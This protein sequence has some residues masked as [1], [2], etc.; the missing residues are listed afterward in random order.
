V[1]SIVSRTRSFVGRSIPLLAGAWICST[2]AFAG[3]WTALTHQAPGGVN[4]MLLLPD[5]TV[6]CANNDGNNIGNAWYRL[7]PDVH[8]SY[9]NG[10]WTSLASSHDTR[11]YY[12]AEV[13]RDGRVFVAGGE[14]GTG[15]PKAEVYDPQ[16][17]A[18]TQMNPP[19]G[20]WN[21]NSDNFYDCNSEVLPDGKVLVMPVFP[22]T[23]GVPLRFD[24]AT[25][26]WSNAGHLFRGSYQDE[27]TWVKLKDDSI[28]TIDPFGTNSERFIPSTNSWVDDGIVPVSLYDPFGF[29][30]GGAALLPDGRAFYLGSTGHTALYTPSGTTSPGTWTAGPDIPGNHGTPDAPC[31]MMV[32]GNVLCA[33]SPV[34][35]SA[36]HFPSP[37]TFYEYDPV[38]NAFNSQNAPGGGSSD[39]GPSYQKDMLD[40][41]DGTV[42]FSH[43]TTQLYV[44]QPSGVPLAAGKPT[45]TSVAQNADGSYHLVGTGLNGISEGASYGDDLQ[46][47]S[48]YPLVRVSDNAGNVYYGRTYNWSSTGV[49]TGS[50]PVSTEFR[51]PNNLPPNATQLVVVANGFASDPYLLTTS[52]SYSC[53][54]DGTD[55]FCPCV[56][57][58]LPG[59]GCENSGSTGGAFLFAA[60]AASLAH[61]TVTFNSSGEMPTA[62]SVVLQGTVAI[63]AVPYG[64]GLRCTGGSLKRLFI[65]N[66]V[67]GVVT[68]PQGA[69]PSVSFQSA[70]LGDPLSAGATRIYQVYY[71]D[72]DPNFCPIPGSTFNVSN[73]VTVLWGN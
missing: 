73:A 4:L 24:P 30:L 70:A 26:T 72:P 28:L 49:Q 61:D 37:T 33:V 7:T 13:M 2:S 45:I 42:L 29:E 14:Y 9:V 69:D 22:H 25:N 3:T 46:M 50:T 17:N 1:N 60:G 20:L 59:H 36:N 56:N 48:N 32:T 38:A 71:R 5:G 31:A 35:T 66:A 62:L 47:N 6:M 18:W 19:S 40:L 27:A 57:F 39:S 23:S 54:G 12:P 10:T 65:H 52:F 16:A 44:Y 63:P 67:G 58:G 53:L 68:A 41:P 11:L 8:G 15:G 64:D 43:W 55:Q 21:V 34:P 51:L